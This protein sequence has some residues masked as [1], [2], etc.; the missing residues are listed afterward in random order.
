MPKNK[1]KVQTNFRIILNI[2]D[3]ESNQK[4]NEKR[5]EPVLAKQ[6]SQSTNNS[7]SVA[8][9]FNGKH[10]RKQLNKQFL[11]EEPKLYGNRRNRQSLDWI[12]HSKNVE[13]AKCYIEKLSGKRTNQSKKN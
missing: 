2:Q 3:P 10:V 1:A 11:N 6:L 7:V 4:L 9:K 13:T 5:R 12:K 8:S